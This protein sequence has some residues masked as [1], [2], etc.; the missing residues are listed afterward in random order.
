MRV[1]L[2]KPREPLGNDEQL[3]AKEIAGVAEAM[4]TK[5]VRHE[6]TFDL[7][8]SGVLALQTTSLAALGGGVLVSALYDMVCEDVEAACRRDGLGVRTSQ[9]VSPSGPD[10]AKG[11]AVRVMNE[12]EKGNSRR[13]R[14]RAWSYW[15]QRDGHPSP[16]FGQKRGER[17][18]LPLPNDICS[19]FSALECV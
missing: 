13:S 2:A 8:R 5:L 16:R 10:A 11:R 18:R 7:G 9:G 14:G 17:G 15:R 1:L 19:S 3:E 4:G 12:K 6:R